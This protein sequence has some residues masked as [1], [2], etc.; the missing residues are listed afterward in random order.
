MPEKIF[1][2]ADDFSGACEMAAIAFRYGLKS[3]IQLEFNP[4]SSAQAIVFDSDSRSL[5]KE[6]AKEKIRLWAKEA[7]NSGINFFIFKKIDSVLRGHIIAEAE[8]LHRV[9]GKKQTFILPA[10]P[11][12]NRLIFKGRYFIDKKPLDQTAFRNDPDFPRLTSVIADLMDQK[13][14]HKHLARPLIPK[15]PGIFTADIV[16]LGDLD[17][18]IQI[19]AQS[20]YCG[21]ADAFEVFLQKA[22]SLASGFEKKRSPFTIR[23][24]LFLC[25]GGS[26]QRT[27]NEALLEDDKNMVCINLPAEFVRSKVFKEEIAWN[28]WLA[29]L[30]K[31]WLKNRFI[32]LSSPREIINNRTAALKIVDLLSR[33]AQELVQK[34]EDFRIHILA[35]GGA[36]ASAIVRKM[37]EKKFE[38]KRELAPGVVTIS[39]GGRLAVTVKPGSYAWPKLIFVRS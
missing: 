38:V 16:Q 31:I 21:G 17:R 30:Q 8:I 36:T 39:D 20:L 19:D 24:D 33:C 7:L 29:Q 34:K 14:K 32:F 26:T 10:N 4:H 15:E 25:V 6:S 27:H 13:Y 12:K 22:W 28:N 23:A 3:E 35:T 18:L 11:S 1:I 9:F 2:L 5:K 37:G